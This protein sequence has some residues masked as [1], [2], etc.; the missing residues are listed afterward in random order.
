MV[1][2]WDPRVQAGEGRTMSTTAHGRAEDEPRRTSAAAG[3][4][5]RRAPLWSTALGAFLFA[6]GVVLIYLLVALWP[7]VQQAAAGKAVE[8]ITWFGREWRPDPET[9]FLIVVV[10]AASLGSYVHAATSFSDYAGNRMLDPSWIWW[11][12]LRGFVGVGLATLFYFALRGGYLGADAV[13]DRLN[14][15]GVAAVA[16]LIGLFSKQA[17]DKLSEIFDVAFRTGT[18]RGDDVRQGKLDLGE[19]ER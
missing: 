11:Y 3:R 16:G 7:A 2:L 5:Q 10:L 6:L 18:K 19:E 8:P 1:D 9:A 12:L 13:A 14:P 4:G 15:Y 17:T